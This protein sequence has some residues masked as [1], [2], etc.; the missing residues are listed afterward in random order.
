[1]NTMFTQLAVLISAVPA[2]AL[3]LKTTALALIGLVVASLLRHAR[4]SV[5]H[6]VLASTFAALILVPLGALL[7]PTI[8]V[9]VLVAR[10]AAAPSPP[11]PLPVEHQPLKAISPSSTL[12]IPVAISRTTLVLGG[13]AAGVLLCAGPLLAALWQLRRL[14]RTSLP[15]LEG[16]TLVDSLAR[17]AGITTSVAALLH[18]TMAAPVTCGVIDPVVILPADAPRWSAPS[19]RRAIVHELEH[20]RRSDWWVHVAARAICALYW[21]NP[22]VWRAYRQ[23]VLEAERACDDA[24]M[25]KE[26]G[27]QYAEQLVALA[28]RLSAGG[29]Q[30]ALAM[31]ARSDLARRVSA[32]LD[33]RQARGRA[34]RVRIAL[35]AALAS[36]LALAIAP[37]RTVA[38]LVA[39]TPAIG[40]QG[41]NRAR[42]AALDRALVETAESG[43]VDELKSLLDAGA[44]VDATVLGDGSALIIA[45]REGHLRAVSLLLD[46]GAD[47]NLG[48]P[49]DGNPLIMAAREGHL[50]IVELLLNRG[51]SIDQVVDGDE[52]ALIQASGEGRLDVVKLLV[53]RGANVNARVWAD[54]AYRRPNGEWRTPLSMARR[55]GHRE[56]ETLLLSAGARE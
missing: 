8:A 3:V 34:G 38:S 24:V 53:V 37:L 26:E 11:R 43:D 40:E 15:W 30:P 39:D 32:V 47:P 1:V 31:A 51:A 35:V 36:T 4:A 7:L 2:L 55:G 16:Q 14:H 28:R 25:E 56:V 6:L 18:D 49:G 50:E 21:F 33:N 23:L 27:A 17:E 54:S 22:V 10:A 19:L 20:V 12:D 29:A 48:V 13:W 45:A 41:R 42:V 44:Q 52:N 46:R 5:R 9:P